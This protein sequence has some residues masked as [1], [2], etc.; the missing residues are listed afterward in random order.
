MIFNFL[1]FAVFLLMTLSIYF[2][3]PEKI[4]SIWLLLVSYAFCL[5]YGRKSF[6]ILVCSTVI[7]YLFGIALDRV[8]YKRQDNRQLIILL[9]AG[10]LFCILPFFIGKINKYSL[11]V[12]VGMSFY[13]LQQIG[14]LIDI[15]Y[16]R[17]HAEK[18]FIRYALFIAFFPKLVS[19]P[20][21]RSDNLMKQIKEIPM[22]AFDYDR[23][24]NGLLLMGWGYFQKSI[25]ADSLDI[26]VSQVYEQWE[27]Y[28]GG[29][30]GLA[31]IVFAFQLYADFSGYTNIALGAAQVLGFRLLDN[32]RQ[33]YL[34][35][36]I[37]EFWRRWHVSFSSWLRDYIYIPLGGGRKGNIRRYMNLM[38][39]FLVSG[40]WHGS[41]WNFVAWGMLH[42]VFQVLE[43]I[44]S[45]IQIKV[46]RKGK[47]VNVV[48]RICVFV[49]VD[50]AW[51][52]FRAS[53]LMAAIG[54]LKKMI[55]NFSLINI[56]N[57]IFTALHLNVSQILLMIM[58]IVLLVAVDLIH[59]RGVCI[60]EVMRE[61]NIMVRWICYLTIILVLTLTGIRRWGVEASDFI[62][63]QF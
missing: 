5:T 48:K 6:F 55:S 29:T 49:L 28:S 30:L 50:I 15:F 57:D 23:V 3:V 33:P 40:F 32:F 17:C 26:Y 14:Y 38:I 56:K 47:V 9:L 34:S 12:G 51:I 42:G 31:T 21:E 10:V 13:L 22:A 54:I 44:C 59:E 4:R 39:T 1:C 18:N 19:G 62:Y 27:A 61:K 7:S 36:S 11:F 41:S 58:A 8:K 2:T 60:R 20:I 43:D 16:G 37:K 24:K 35:N 53:G 25:I 52:F 45:R 46:V 63:M